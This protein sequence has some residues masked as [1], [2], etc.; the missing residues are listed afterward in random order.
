MSGGHRNIER[1]PATYEVST[2]V[3]GGTLVEFDASNAG[4]VKPAAAN[5]ILVAGVALADANPAGTDPTNP[6]QIGWAREFVAVAYGPIDVDVTYASAAK[7]GD[8]LVAAASGQVTKYTAASSTYD[9][10]VGRCSAHAAVASGDV[11]A[12]RLFG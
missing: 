4:K 6:V 11:A 8:L 10:I 2:A 12:V 9:Q 7:P 3:T 5:S 1:G